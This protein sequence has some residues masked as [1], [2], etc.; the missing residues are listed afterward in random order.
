MKEIRNTKTYKILVENKW[1]SMV[2]PRHGWKNIIMDLK[3]WGFVSKKWI[4]AS[5]AVGSCGHDKGGDWR[6][7]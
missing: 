1:R 5:S 2:R 7:S 3:E 4:Q 6:F